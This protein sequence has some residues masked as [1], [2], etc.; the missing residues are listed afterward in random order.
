MRHRRSREDILGIISAKGEGKV[1]S[2]M[3][4]NKM[5]RRKEKGRG[6]EVKKNMTDV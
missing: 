2:G 4:H 1:F 3:I 6:V 5:K